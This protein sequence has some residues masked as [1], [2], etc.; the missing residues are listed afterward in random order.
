[1]RSILV[2]RPQPVADEFA[3]KLRREGFQTY[4]APL[5]EYVE[6][7]GALGD[8]SV[9]QACVFTSAQAV[10]VFCKKTDDRHLPALVV[11]EATARAA[12]QAG[13]AQ[14]YSAEG[15]AST[16]IAL[17]GD[18][19]K[20]MSLK[21]VIHPCSDDT[22]N[23]IAKAVTRLGVKMVMKVIYKANFITEFPD[24][25]MQ[26]LRR[27]GIDTITLFSAR[28][29]ANFVKILCRKEWR[30]VSAKLNVV[31]ISKRVADK[32][33]PLPW[34]TVSVA[35]QPHTE[36]MLETLKHNYPYRQL[37]SAFVNRR[38]KM[39]RRQHSPET[40]EQGNISAPSYAGIDRR[41]GIDRRSHEERQHARVLQERMKIVSNTLTSFAFI[42]IAVV[43]SGV[44]L[45]GPEYIHFTTWYGDKASSVKPVEGFINRQIARV[46]NVTGAAAEVA[47]QLV[48][49]DGSVNSGELVS[50]LVQMLGRVNN[51]RNT[52][53]GNI[54][55]ERSMARLRQVLSE[56]GNPE[57]LRASINAAREK[58]STLDS[59]LGGVGWKNVA[60]A[61][62]LLALNEFRS[63]VG[64]HRPYED[65]IA[66]MQRLAGNDPEMNLALQRLAPYARSGIIGRKA[67][68]KEF[69]QFATDIVM[70]EV[71]GRDISVKEEVLKR[72]NSFSTMLRV[73]DIQGQGSEAVAARAN[74]LMKQGD[75]EGAMHE[76]QFLQGSSAAAAQ[77][78]MES[79][80][81]YLIADQSSDFLT[82]KI[83]QTLPDGA[84]TGMDDIL[85][86]LKE[87]APGDYRPVPLT[88]GG[89]GY[90][91]VLAP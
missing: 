36:A 12:R 46:R 34:H 64:N 15:D 76:L 81:E 82:R 28:S 47:H 9:Y 32:L 5:M 73:A 89:K 50:R 79:A 43:L 74:L 20:S 59:L 48:A 71:Q 63:N 49:P 75:V 65:D 57:T 24:D 14:V 8:L 51:L 23:D 7:K 83:L 80:A 26:A 25:V 61:G 66:L 86:V 21:K 27:N 84:S 58:D 11:G 90:A 70:A 41:T 91:G 62:M 67:L 29:A 45:M 53:D 38:E 1:M 10:Q 19:V 54:T 52:A 2:T 55:L 16:M 4:I 17:I 33:K 69:N 44:L 88:S 3:E 40:D 22:P 72:F 60:A 77:P 31:C 13:F 78:W 18:R 39:E 56:G 35:A 87:M 37:D 68:E 85:S 30:G 42:F 6:V